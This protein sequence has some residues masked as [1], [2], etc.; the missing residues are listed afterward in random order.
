MLPDLY[1]GRSVSIIVFGPL[2]QIAVVLT[3]DAHNLIYTVSF[4]NHPNFGP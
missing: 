2:P 4:T 3:L 1:M